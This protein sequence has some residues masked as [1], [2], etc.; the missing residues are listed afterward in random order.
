VMEL[1]DGIYWKREDVIGR[2]GRRGGGVKS[3][4]GREG[5]VVWTI[6]MGQSSDRSKE[7]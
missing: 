4:R 1:I 6:Y 2:R 5:T 7:I 3:D